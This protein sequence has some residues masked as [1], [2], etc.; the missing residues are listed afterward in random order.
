MGW[1]VSVQYQSW[2]RYFSLSLPPN[3][4]TNESWQ[5]FFIQ[6]ITSTGQYITMPSPLPTKLL[7]GVMLSYQDVFR[8]TV[9]K[10]LIH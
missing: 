1:M 9:V 2:M 5:S 8:K 6:L 10:V 4:T 3:L 7:N